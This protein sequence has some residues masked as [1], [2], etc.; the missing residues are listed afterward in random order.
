MRNRQPI[1]VPFK[2]AS[3]RAERQPAAHPDH[4]PERPWHRQTSEPS[5][6]PEHHSR[7]CG[8]GPVHIEH[9]IGKERGAA[10]AIKEYRLV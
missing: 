4:Q 7:K 10:S 2:N 3:Q 5:I 1:E 6:E 8:I 9:Q